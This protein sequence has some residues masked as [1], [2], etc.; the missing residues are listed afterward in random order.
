MTGAT[1]KGLRKRIAI[2]I[3]IVIVAVFMLAGR[4]AW[5][6]FVQGEQLSE[7][8]RGQVQDQRGLLSPR[9]TI[10]DRNGREMAV[11]FLAKSLYV[12]PEE[13][14]TNQRDSSEIAN[15]LA[16]VLTMEAS[17]IQKKLVEDGRFVWIKRTLDPDVSDKIAAII[18]DHSLKGFAFIEESKRYYPNETLAAQVLGF[19]GT[20]DVGLDGLEMALDGTI[21]GSLAKHV[22]DTDSRGIPIFQSVF[23]FAP[24]KQGKNV[25]LTLDA[26]IQ[27]I[28]EDCLDKAMTS[29]RSA[30]ATVIV[31]NPRTGDVLAMANRPTFNPNSFYKYSSDN[32]RNR[33]V[34]SLY[35]PG[36][37]FKS[38]VA[39][40]ALQEGLVQPNDRFVDTGYV[41]VSGRR[42]KN[43]SGDSYGSVTFIDVMKNSINTGFVHLSMRLGATRLTNYTRAFGFGEATNIELPG[44]GLGILFKPENMRESDLATMS[45]GQSI[46]VTPLQLATAMAAIANDGVLLRPHIIKEIQNEDGSIYSASSTQVVRQVISLDT[47]R[48]LT[49]MLEKVVSEGGAK[50]AAVKGYRIA[51]K[52]GTAEKP[53]EDGRGY[54]AGRYIASFVGFAPVENPQ[55]V[56]LVVLDDPNGAYYGGEIA[57]PVAGE[58]FA[59]VLRYLN[60]HPLEAQ[61]I[62]PKPTYKTAAP[63]VAPPTKPVPAG[64]VIVPDLRGKTLRQAGELLSKAGLGMIPEGSGIAAS[65]SIQPNTVVDVASEVRVYFQAR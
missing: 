63:V 19:V 3:T 42:I 32:W 16:P 5:I 38:I 44:E 54:Y 41:E 27:F 31:M 30:G 59:K 35:E 10:F 56:V 4:L 53:R 25:Y 51:G 39:A 57:A 23:T 8:A 47:S 58:I 52:T 14:K 28:V 55:I 34:A 29:T 20:D 17:E 45:I 2:F 65:Q 15:L 22:V 64:K 11:S 21:K 13:A 37:T 48:T 40:A 33:A 6:Q 18:K 24:P 7:K 9:G 62:L 43:W 1:G 49:E 60:V 12:D 36:S 61:P 46:A 26:T 50:R